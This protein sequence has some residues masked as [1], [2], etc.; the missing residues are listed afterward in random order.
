MTI[1]PEPI[2]IAVF[3][4]SRL[5]LAPPPS[6]GLRPLEL[7]DEIPED[8]LV[9]P[10]PG[11]ALRMVLNGENRQLAMGHP[12][13]RPI[14]QVHVGHLELVR[15]GLRLDRES[16]ILGRDVDPAGTEVLHRLVPPAVTELQL[17]GARPE[18]EGNE[19]VA[20]ADPQ[21]GDAPRELPRRLHGGRDD[22]R[23]GGVARATRTSSRPP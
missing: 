3:T 2:P 11:T 13:D 19:L 8:V 5:G 16:V 21:E 20:E 10:G 15:E 1:G 23:V 14:V 6:R 9:V 17:E 7:R 18:G 4:S 22:V 12:F